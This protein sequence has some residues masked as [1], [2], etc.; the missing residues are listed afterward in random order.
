[1]SFNCRAKGKVDEFLLVFLFQLK[2]SNTILDQAQQPYNYLID[3][4]RQRDA[5]INKQKEHI[6]NLEADVQ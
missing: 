5:Q 3:S 6:T 2:N 4:V 1:M